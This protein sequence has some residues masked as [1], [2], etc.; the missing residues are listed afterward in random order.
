MKR[1][2][3]KMDINR[4]NIWVFEKKKKKKKCLRSDGKWENKEQ[5]PDINKQKPEKEVEWGNWEENR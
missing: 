2:S 4:I 5:S 1:D 3:E